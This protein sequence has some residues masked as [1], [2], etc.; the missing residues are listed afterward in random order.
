MPKSSIP[1]ARIGLSALLL[2]APLPVGRAEAPAPAAVDAAIDQ[3]IALDPVALLTH[4]GTLREQSAK[5]A[6]EAAALRAEADR[7]DAEAQ[8]KADRLAALT[9]HTEALI[10]ALGLAPPPAETMA[11]AAAEAPPAADEEPLTNFQDHVLP[12]FRARCASCHNPDQRKSG[13]AS[14]TAALVLEGG[15]SGAVVVPGDPEGSRLLRL[16]SHAEEPVMPPSGDPLTPEQVETIRRWIADGAPADAS[17]KRMAKEEA[18]ADA[19]AGGLYVAATFADTPPLPEVA[20]AAA[21]PLAGRGVVARAVDANPRAPLL[22][23][24]SKREVLLYNTES[25]AL[26]GALPFPEGDVYTLTFSV[27][28]ELLAVGGGEEGQAG[29]CVVY[30]VRSGKRLGAYG[31]YYDTVLAADISPDHRMIA[32]GGPNKR[33]RVYAADDGRELYALDAH[34][35]WIQAVKFTP[36]GEVLA[37]ADRAGGLYLWQAANGRP[38][39]QLRGHE[40]AIYALA[41]T[42]D[43]VHLA[44]AGKDGTVQIWDTWKYS[45]VRSFKAHNAAVLGLDIGADSRIVTS[46]ADRQT[47]VWNLEGKEERKIDALPDWGYQAQFTADAG[48]VAV[49]TWDGAVTLWS[50]ASGEIVAALNTN[51]AAAGQG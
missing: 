12:I 46:G 18:P 14:T 49:G 39:E 25:F 38:V 5:Q 35:D 22:A 6:E 47:R 27:N 31:E 32:L 4:L 51:P 8:G 10:K 42:P 36:D 13:F 37:T 33:V 15:S 16:V 1:F 7:L 17:A 23:V 24:G 34:T 20:L 44:S 9:S 2:L 50:P 30:E 11:M 19:D 29:L 48:L 21:S 45:R 43:S 26:L 3:L 40:G 41:Y 28:G